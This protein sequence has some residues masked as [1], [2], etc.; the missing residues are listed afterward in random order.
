MWIPLLSEPTLTKEADLA[1]IREQLESRGAL[2]IFKVDSL[3]SH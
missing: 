3:I 2:K 1:F